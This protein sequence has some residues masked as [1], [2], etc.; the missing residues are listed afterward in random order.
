MLNGEKEESCSSVSLVV[1]KPYTDLK[2]SNSSL[3]RLLFFFDLKCLN[4]LRDS[5]SLSR[6]DVMVCSEEAPVF[7]VFEVSV[8]RFTSKALADPQHFGAAR[9]IALNLAQW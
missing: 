8:L 2:S 1:S 9:L 4:P 5:L 6:A 3:V 7:F